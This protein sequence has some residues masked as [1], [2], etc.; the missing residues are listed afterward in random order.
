VKVVLTREARRALEQISDYVAEENPLAARRLVRTLSA[1]AREIA[2]RPKAW[3]IAS[4]SGEL[5][6]RRR[7]AGGYLIFYR[8]EAASISIIHI[9]HGAQDY[10]ALLF[11]D[12]E[13]P[14]PLP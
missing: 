1:K 6:I 3:P 13:P 8:I 10:E 9:V 5:G 4:G 7:V 11:P 12:G 2:E 14:E